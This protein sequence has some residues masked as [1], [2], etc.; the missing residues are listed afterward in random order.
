MARV[1]PN[2]KTPAT[3]VFF[4]FLLFLFSSMCCNIVYSYTFTCCIDFTTRPNYYE[5][6]SACCSFVVARLRH[7]SLLPCCLEN[8]CLYTWYMIPHETASKKSQLLTLSAVMSKLFLTSEGTSS[9]QQQACSA[10][11][12]SPCLLPFARLPRHS[13]RMKMELSSLS[14]IGEETR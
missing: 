2:I 9:R 3:F 13:R 10:A 1:F 8:C 6:P 5:Y 4:C 7:M 12:D 14:E 11:T